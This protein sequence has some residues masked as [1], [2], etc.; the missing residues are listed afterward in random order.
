MAPLN[1]DEL[2]FVEAPH[3]LFNLRIQTTDAKTKECLSLLCKEGQ[4]STMLECRG[5]LRVELTSAHSPR[6]Q[7]H[8]KALCSGMDS[9]YKEERGGGEQA[10]FSVLSGT[11]HSRMQSICK[12]IVLNYGIMFKGKKN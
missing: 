12:E 10:I 3:I 4:F 7:K 11:L 9:T 8:R 5:T 6:P 1:E 2:Y